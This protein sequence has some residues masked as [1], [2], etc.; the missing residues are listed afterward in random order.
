M[1]G[2]V[3]L[4]RE[5]PQFGPSQMLEEGISGEI[6]H[7]LLWGSFPRDVAFI[8]IYQNDV[9]QDIGVVEGIG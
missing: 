8:E 1:R 2:G 9:C 6:F 5:Y 4:S 7:P 3:P